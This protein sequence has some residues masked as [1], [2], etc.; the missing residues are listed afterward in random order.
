MRR[1]AGIAAAACLAWPLGPAPAG[2][3]EIYKFTD[4]EG[5]V[6]YTNVKP[7]GNID[8]RTF[9]FPCYASDPKC[10]AVDWE[11]VP[12]NTSVFRDEIRTA[13]SR[14]ELEE[15]LIRAIIHAESAYQPDAVSP[16]GAEGLMQLMPEVQ[17]ELKV[18]DPSVPERNIDGGA[19][20]L[21]RLLRQFGG[22]VEL[23]AAAYNAGAGAVERHNGVPP[24]TETREY[25]RRVQI[26]YRRYR[27]AGT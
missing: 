2:A 27:L 9:T 7:H 22:N 19:F 11:Q 13:A 8:Y 1:L 26:L 25:V 10:R 5:I 15:S 17:A 20:H 14:Y 3:S 21:S 16:K 24:Y 23:A 6:H 4:A 12:L 18:A